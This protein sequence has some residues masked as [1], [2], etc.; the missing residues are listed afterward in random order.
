ML[1]AGFWHPVREKLRARHGDIGIIAQCAAA[2]DLSPRP[3]HYRKAE[4]RRYKLKYPKLYREYKRNPLRYPEGFF[5]NAAEE[6]A[7]QEGNL[8]DLL[9]AEDIANRISAGFNEVLAWA[10]KDKLKNPV[11]RHEVAGVQLDRRLVTEEEYQ[12]FRQNIDR[13]TAEKKRLE[14]AGKPLPRT[15]VSRMGR[16][17]GIIRRYEAQKKEPKIDTTIHAVRIGDFAFASNRFE[18]FIDFMHRIQG[19]S[20]F[21]QTIIVQLTADPGTGGG[22]YLATKRAAANL[23]YSATLLSNQV[24]P[25]G[26]QQLVETTLEMLNKLKEEK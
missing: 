1:H 24:S 2:G 5:I 14:K 7:K 3:M 21:T 17:R 12:E 11:L 18:L 10:Q 13:L 23:G 16:S 26:G 19:R 9:R 15:F 22:T 6:K 25:E 20:P 8:C 4:L